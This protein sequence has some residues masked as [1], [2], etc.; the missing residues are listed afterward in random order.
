[1]TG[2]TRVSPL[3]GYLTASN[4]AID[5][6]P[7]TTRTLYHE[8]ESHSLRHY[9]L[10]SLYYFDFLISHPSRN[11]SIA[12]WLNGEVPLIKK[13]LNLKQWLTI[14]DAARHLGILFGEDVSEADVLRLALDGHLTLSVYFVNGARGRCGPI[15]RIED[16][17]RT[18][19]EEN[20]DDWIHLMGSPPPG[21]GE[22]VQVF[23]S[24]IHGLSLGD[25]RVIECAKETELL[26]GVWD[27]TMLGHERLEVDQRY[28]FLT[29][30][31]EVDMS[32]RDGPLDHPIVSRED[33]TLCQLHEPY[34]A[35]KHYFPADALPA[36]SVLVVRTSA[37]HDLEKRLA[38]PDQ[39]AERPVEQ[40]ERTSLLAIMAALA[41]LAKIDV[42]KPSS[43]AAAIERQTDL[44][45][46]RVAARTIENHLKL[47][48]EVLER[49][50][51]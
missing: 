2:A 3:F 15:V 49:L 1:M 50:S 7:K 8:F 26:D 39:R 6:T 48:P 46:A 45:G 30:G 51:K 40:R 35:D 12:R 47:I 23:S 24:F 27:L 22:K 18:I 32:F 9:A 4:S 43:A 10:K 36:D 14:A 11:P 37:L 29:N 5:P 34:F 38:E 31:P 25:G 13:L 16:A 42:T 21:E 33:G 17:Q 19:Q 20:P 41:Q 44:M 28:Q